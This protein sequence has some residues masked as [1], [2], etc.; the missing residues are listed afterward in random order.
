MEE[1]VAAQGALY[2]FA[3]S[4]GDQRLVRMID[5]D[6]SADQSA[7]VVTVEDVQD[8]QRFEATPPQLRLLRPSTH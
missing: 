7:V 4:S 1:S 5:A 2:I 8:K 6:E 3:D